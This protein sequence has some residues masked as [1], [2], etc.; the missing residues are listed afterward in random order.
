M[1]YKIAVASSDKKS[2]DLSFGSVKEI[3]IYEV[4]EAGVEKL[5]ECRRIGDGSEVKSASAEISR[6]GNC[7]GHGGCGC[8][9]GGKDL[10]SPKAEALSDCRCVV[11]SSSGEKI[12]KI[13]SSKG[14]S[15]FDITGDIK[16]ILEKIKGYYQ[17]IDR[18]KY[19]RNDSEQL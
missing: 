9:C 8:G 19:E 2:V 4:D 6:D 18:F 14:I 1:S 12:K 15:V 7:G 16:D 17:R 11:V 5:T 10:H 3:Y 13:F